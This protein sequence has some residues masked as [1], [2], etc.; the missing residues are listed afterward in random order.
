MEHRQ[1]AFKPNI[2]QKSLP[3]RSKPSSKSLRKGNTICER[4]EIVVKT[5]VQESLNDMPKTFDFAKKKGKQLKN[6]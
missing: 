6:I 1:G 4:L 3:R 5:K 2:N